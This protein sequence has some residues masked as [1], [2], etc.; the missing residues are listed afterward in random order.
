MSICK[1]CQNNKALFVPHPC[2]ETLE[3]LICTDCADR[4][5]YEFDEIQTGRAIE[6]DLELCL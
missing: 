2:D 1:E 4:I 6:R 5:M 3:E